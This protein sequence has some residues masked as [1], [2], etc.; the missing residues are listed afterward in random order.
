MSQITYGLYFI[1][2]CTLSFP[3]CSGDVSLLSGLLVWQNR[4][5]PLI[6]QLSSLSAGLV[7]FVFCYLLPYKRERVERIK[8]IKKGVNLFIACIFLTSITFFIFYNL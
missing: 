4:Q 3:S 6:T 8:A 2:L 5:L 7:G 1:N